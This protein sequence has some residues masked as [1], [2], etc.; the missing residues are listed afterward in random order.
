[1]GDRLLDSLT[2]IAATA[3]LVFLG[4]QWHVLGRMLDGAGADVPA[5]T[6]STRPG[7]AVTGII[8]PRL[9]LSAL[10]KHAITLE[11]RRASLV[12]PELGPFQLN[13]APKSLRLDAAKAR[14]T[15]P[16]LR[17]VAEHC[18]LDSDHLV[19][20]GAVRL[21]DADGKGLLF[22]DRLELSLARDH[23]QTGEVAILTPEGTSLGQGG[24]VVPGFSATLH[25][26]L[27]RSR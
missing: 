23:L 24:R 18:R 16:A 3:L 6:G 10:G 1:V 5:G 2:L 20:S 4:W 27:S 22:S 14:L 25:A 11:A 19:F 13:L 9:Q 17:I 26:L 12:M 7:F 8:G 15:D 21:D